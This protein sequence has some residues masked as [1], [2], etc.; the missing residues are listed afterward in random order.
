[1]TNKKIR[2]EIIPLM[3]IND[4]YMYSETDV[5]QIQ[6]ITRKD[7]RL[8]VLEEIEKIS[9]GSGKHEQRIIS[10]RNYIRNILHCFFKSSKKM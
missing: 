10:I 7:E 9:N 2:I 5:E 8:M 6:Q 1:M 3:N 4:G